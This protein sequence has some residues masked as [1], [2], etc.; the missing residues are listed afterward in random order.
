MKERESKIKRYICVQLEEV[1]TE[2]LESV[3]DKSSPVGLNV[4]TTELISCLEAVFVHKLRDSFIDKVAYV[5]TGEVFKQP[6]PNLWTLILSISHKHQVIALNES[7]YITTDIGRSRSWI[8]LVLNEGLMGSFVESLR[9]DSRLLNQFYEKDAFLKDSDCCLRLRKQLALLAELYFDLPINSS[10]LNKWTPA[11]LSLAGIWVPS[12][13]ITPEAVVQGCDVAGTISCEQSIATN[14]ELENIV[15]D[16]IAKSSP[17]QSTPSSLF[18][19]SPKP[20]PF[21]SFYHT[22]E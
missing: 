8:R 3:T 14:S 20:T 6:E 10:L 21:G 18:G 19:G 15:F 5:L 9:R 7:D 22:F 17:K 1:T 16:R 2:L 11:P 13:P 4:I 12:A